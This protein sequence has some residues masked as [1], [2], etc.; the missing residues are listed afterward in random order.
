VAR[1]LSHE[2]N[3]STVSFGRFGRIRFPATTTPDMRTLFFQSANTPHE[4]TQG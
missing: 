3:G 2:S 1:D 4:A